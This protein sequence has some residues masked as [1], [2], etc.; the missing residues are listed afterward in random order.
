MKMVSRMV[1]NVLA[2]EATDSRPKYDWMADVLNMLSTFFP[3]GV[4]NAAVKLVADSVPVVI[5]GKCM[6]SRPSLPIRA[7]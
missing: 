2:S 1:S 7:F 5:G 3:S 4:G 6:G